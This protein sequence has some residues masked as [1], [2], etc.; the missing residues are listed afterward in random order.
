ME[1]DSTNTRSKRNLHAHISILDQ[2][3]Y[4]EVAPQRT[5]RRR[6]EG[7]SSSSDLP[8]WLLDKNLT[9]KEKLKKLLR[10]SEANKGLTAAETDKGLQLVSYMYRGFM[11]GS[12]TLKENQKF[13]SLGKHLLHAI[14]KRPLEVRCFGKHV[15]LLKYLAK[16]GDIA[17]QD[18]TDRLACFEDL[19]ATYN[20]FH[21]HAIDLFR[22]FDLPSQDQI[23]YNAVYLKIFQSSLELTE[24]VA[25]QKN[26]YSILL[27]EMNGY[28]H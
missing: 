28:Y 5:K 22:K 6:T 4:F 21:T 26:Y 16:I 12:K 23:L 9:S 13:L 15:N 2:T 11:A 17:Y 27:R 19:L 7:W 8:N 10:L 24:D 18:P 25:D 3:T 20:S 14:L 1:V